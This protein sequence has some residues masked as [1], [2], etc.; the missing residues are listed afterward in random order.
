MAVFDDSNDLID[1]L[2]NQELLSAIEYLWGSED[3]SANSRFFDALVNCHLI[4]VSKGG[5]EGPHTVHSGRA[6]GMGWVTAGEGA[7]VNLRLITRSDGATGLAVFS[8]MESYRRLGYSD[9]RDELL[10]M[11]SVTILEIFMQLDAEF[12]VLNPGSHLTAE[13]SKD[14]VYDCLAQRSCAQAKSKAEGGLPPE[15]RHSLKRAKAADPAPKRS[16]ARKHRLS[17]REAEVLKQLVE[18]IPDQEL[19]ELRQQ[20]SQAVARICGLDDGLLGPD[21]RLMNAI[22]ERAMMLIEV[23]PRRSTKEKALITGAVRYFW[24][25]RDAIPDSTSLIGLDDD[26]RVMNFV[27]EE[28]G[29]EEAF[30]DL[31]D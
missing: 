17:Q 6:D 1:Q 10:M 9:A 27:L 25:H 12:F 3:A 4:V 2:S 30:I 13:M 18:A 5:V 16:A 24:S 7:T 11:D 22:A 14:Q 20:V 29:F 19:F 21:Q 31:D 8:D 28:L 26:A 23:Y 15:L